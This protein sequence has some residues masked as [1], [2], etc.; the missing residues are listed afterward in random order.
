MRPYLMTVLALAAINAIASAQLPR[1]RC[2]PICPPA[3]DP[4]LRTPYAEGQPNFPNPQEMMGQVPELN[5]NVFAQQNEGG[6]NSARMFNDSFH[7]DFGGIICTCRVITSTT[8]GRPGTLALGGTDAIPPGS[9][10]QLIRLPAGSRYNGILN[11]DNDSARPTTRAYFGYNYYENA[12]AVYNGSAGGT[13]INRETVAFEY[14]F[15][16]GNASVGMRLPFIQTSAPFGLSQSFVG[17]LSILSKYAFYNNRQTGDVASVGM[18]VTAPTGGGNDI[19]LADG[20]NIPTSVLLQPWVGGVKMYDRGYIQEMTGLLVPLD[21]R[22]PFIFN[23][24][25]GAGYFLYQNPT[26]RF[27]RAVV[28]NI[29]VHA[30]VPLNNRDPNGVIFLQ[31]QVNLTTGIHFRS[32]RATL[33]P[34]INVPLAGPKPWN[35]EATV[36]LN[37]FF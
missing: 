3:G 1:S 10:T 24:S 4:Y 15:L 9:T 11:S 13:N 14:A 22:E 25:V 7:G 35:L 18:I 21:T 2:A 5:P 16:D 6:G 29:E 26:D 8:S 37:V 17:D 31:D 30:R 34:A 32:N 12:N 28:P 27:L 23:A 36:W 19:V 20:S 33:S